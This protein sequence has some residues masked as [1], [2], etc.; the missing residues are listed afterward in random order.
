MGEDATAAAIVAAAARVE[1]SMAA[2]KSR[3]DQ[4]LA[5]IHHLLQTCST[6]RA[7]RARHPMTRAS[8]QTRMQTKAPRANAY[9]IC[10]C[11]CGGDSGM[12]TTALWPRRPDTMARLGKFAEE[13][14]D[15]R[16]GYDDHSMW[17]ER[18]LYPGGRS[19]GVGVFGNMLLSAMSGRDVGT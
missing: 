1:A 17:G 12:H 16:S 7:E 14:F 15:H 9:D 4:T 10:P 8:T 18:M 13:A 6:Q 5:G 3:A 19:R 2:A 11:G